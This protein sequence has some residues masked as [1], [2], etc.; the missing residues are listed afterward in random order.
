MKNKLKKVLSYSLLIG[1]VLPI[2]GISSCVKLPSVFDTLKPGDSV[3]KGRYGNNKINSEKQEK[4]NEFAK[5]DKE[6]IEDGRIIYQEQDEHNFLKQGHRYYF[7]DLVINEADYEPDYYYSDKWKELLTKPYSGVADAQ[8]IQEEGKDKEFE[9]DPELKKWFENEFIDKYEPLGKYFTL[10]RNFLKGNEKLTNV[11]KNIEFAKKMIEFLKSADIN[12]ARDIF[13]SGYEFNYPL[14]HKNY[15]KEKYARYFKLNPWFEAYSTNYNVYNQDSIQLSKDYILKEN[16]QKSKLNNENTKNDEVISTRSTNTFSQ[17]F[18]SM[19]NIWFKGIFSDKTN[20]DYYNDED[21]QITILPYSFSTNVKITNNYQWAKNANAY[22][23]KYYQITKDPFI[24]KEVGKQ[25][26][27]PN[28]IDLLFYSQAKN[29]II[30]EKERLLYLS[31]L[32]FQLKLMEFQKL[33][34]KFHLKIEEF[35]G[36]AENKLTEAIK[37]KS[38]NDDQITELKKKAQ[39]LK[40][41]LSEYANTIF[42]YLNINTFALNETQVLEQFIDN[43]PKKGYKPG[44]KYILADLFGISQTD[45]FGYTYRFAYQEFLDTILPFY[46]MY[47]L[48]DNT[49]LTIFKSLITTSNDNISKAIYDYAFFYLNHLFEKSARV[50]DRTKL[51]RWDINE[52]QKDLELNNKYNTKE[53]VLQEFNKIT[54]IYG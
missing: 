27:A 48:K 32:E 40:V 7:K 41:K 42:N 53:K 8:K 34:Q 3:L 6:A 39:E 16:A 12:L 38:L 29:F 54:K 52:Y 50:K 22:N 43:D 19:R 25:L 26:G 18:K 30:E 20:N 4:N 13:D 33:I 28:V 31:A 36:F 51:I 9:K 21:F 44:E 24:N 49:N 5:R 15:Y 14:K 17:A 45:D 35:K 37:D 46:S 47:D 11:D 2:I 10:I 23:E 1:S